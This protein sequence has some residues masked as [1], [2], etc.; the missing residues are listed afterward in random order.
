M[1][2]FTVAILF[3]AAATSNAFMSPSMPASMTRN[4]KLNIMT[5][6]ENDAILKQASDCVEGECSLDD[7]GDLIEILQEQ[8]KELSSRV[9]D[10]RNL[11][12]SLEKVNAQ[13]DRPVDEI[14]ETVRAIFRV[15]QLG[16]KASDNDY[17]KLSRP[18]GYTGEVGK[19][20]QTAYDAL[21][22]KKYKPSP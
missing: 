2:R 16:D 7:V 8:Q 1:N 6:S 12:K 10:I 15:F 14:R 5:S 3:A 18:M 13:E 4:M 11:V 9:E 21:S 22:P 17:P 20:P 19:G